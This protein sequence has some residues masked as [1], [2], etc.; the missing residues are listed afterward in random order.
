MYILYTIPF[1]TV[2]HVQNVSTGKYTAVQYTVHETRKG[3]T[4]K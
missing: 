1:F 3:C 2:L 4:V